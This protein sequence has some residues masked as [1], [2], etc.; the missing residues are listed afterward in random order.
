MT[1][2]VKA[3]LRAHKPASAAGLVLLV[4]VVAVMAAPAFSSSSAGPLTDATS[5]S[6]W[7]STSQAQRNDYARRYLTEHVSLLGKVP[8][9]GSIESAISAGCTRAAYLAEG[10]EVTVIGAI[11][12]QY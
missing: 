6:E 5:C 8:A 7:T 9:A 1:T 2:S 12:H 3:L 4:L 11:K 10:D